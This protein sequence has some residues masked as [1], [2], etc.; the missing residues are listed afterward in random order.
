MMYG[1][2]PTTAAANHASEIDDR[3]RVAGTEVWVRSS[4]TP[5]H[6]GADRDGDDHRDGERERE[7]SLNPTVGDA[8][9]RTPS[10]PTG[11][12]IDARIGEDLDDGSGVAE[13]CP[14]GRSSASR[15]HL[16]HH[17]IRRSFP[18]R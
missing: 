9:R 5:F 17:D 4:M 18:T 10:D 11:P 12:A 8:R 1:I 13:H 16:V 2:A 7:G 15:R 6:P 3:E 14:R